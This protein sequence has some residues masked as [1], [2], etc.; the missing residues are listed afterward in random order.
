VASWKFFLS[1]FFGPKL[2]RNF[3]EATK[4]LVS[5]QATV[6]PHFD[7]F[8]PTYQSLQIYFHLRSALS[9]LV[10]LFKKTFLYRYSLVKELTTSLVTVI[11]NRNLCRKILNVIKKCGTLHGAAH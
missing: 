6:F 10:H 2:R 11:L 9:Q 7:H 1:L 8:L 3:E 4:R 5:N